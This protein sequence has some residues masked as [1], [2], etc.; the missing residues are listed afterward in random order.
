M[1]DQ[2]ESLFKVGKY[3]TSL[4]IASFWQAPDAN[5]TYTDIANKM[6]E[7]ENDDAR[8]EIIRVQ[9]KKREILDAPVGLIGAEP[10]KLSW[11]GCCGTMRQ[12][13]HQ[14]LFEKNVNSA[15]KRK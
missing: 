15:L 5:A 1:Y 14:S 4:V 2:A 9:F 3:L 12:T 8:K 7:L 6:I 10:R 13:E 11:Q